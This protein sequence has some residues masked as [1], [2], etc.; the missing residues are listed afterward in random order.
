M[1]KGTRSTTLSYSSM[2]DGKTAVY[3]TAQI[4]ESGKS[5]YSK[6]IQDKELY[7]ANKTECRAQQQS[8]CHARHF[9]FI[10]YSPSTSLKASTAL[11]THSGQGHSGVPVPIPFSSL[12]MVAPHFS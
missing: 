8:S 12:Q 11:R 3:M 4:P 10:C 1:L 5:N 2:I 7:E 9:V 6:N